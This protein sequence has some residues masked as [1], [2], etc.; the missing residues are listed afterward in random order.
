MA[1][2]AGVGLY[3]GSN[4]ST[5]APGSASGIEEVSYN[6]VEIEDVSFATVVRKSVR[7]SMN[8]GVTQQEIEW[9]AQ[10]VVSNITKQQPVNAIAVAMYHYGDDYYYAARVMVNWAPYGDWSRAIDV[11]TGDY[12]H[13][14][15]SYSYSNI[16]D[17]ILGYTTPATTTPATTTPTT[18]TP[19]PIAL[20]GSGDKVSPQFELFAGITIFEVSHDGTS[21]FIVEL[22]SES[23]ET[24]ELLVNTIGQ[25]TG[26]NA[27]GVQEEAFFGA[28]PGMHL[29]N[30]QA[31]G[32]WS[33]TIRQPR[34][35]SAPGLP[36]NFSGE[37]DSTSTPFLLDAGLATFTLNHDGTSNFIVELLSIEGSIADLLVNDIGSYEG[38]K[39]VGIQQGA[40]FGPEPGI[41]ILSI[42]AD[43]NWSIAIQ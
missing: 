32:T 23:G 10:D 2:V 26:V 6:I 24:I 35:N 18:T 17:L 12:Q 21:N 13:H 34:Y 11:T 31:D 38:S 37:G 36:Q 39:A 22:M 20:E 16:Q 4:D 42:T 15:Y 29:L 41:Y 5:T 1:I 28:E 14:Q 3:L 9:I 40:L 25:Y 27:I 8:A 30:I 7:I 33:I 43:G 19:E